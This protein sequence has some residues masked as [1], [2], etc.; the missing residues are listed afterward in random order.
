MASHINKC[1]ITGF[2][3]NY[4]G[5][6]TEQNAAA[7]DRNN[8][9]LFPSCQKKIDGIKYNS[10]LPPPNVTGNL[11]L[12]HA[13]MITVQDVIFRWKLFNGYNVEWIAGM[14]HAGIATQCVVEQ[15]IQREHGKSRFDI[16]KKEFL[17]KIL[18]WR[19][20]KGPYSFLYLWA[21]ECLKSNSPYFDICRK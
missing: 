12:G 11:H 10:I 1:I 16:G 17:Q 2:S 19:N 13:L 15:K 7:F 8:K 4:N 6:E 18:E 20:E 9:K 5:K 21:F 3:N 14:D